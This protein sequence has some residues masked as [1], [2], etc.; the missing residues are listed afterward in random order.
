M[1]PLVGILGADG[2]K[3][4]A[5]LYSQITNFVSKVLLKSP[6]SIRLLQYFISRHGGADLPLT[7]KSVDPDYIQFKGGIAVAPDRLSEAYFV[8]QKDHSKQKAMDKR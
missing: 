2:F 5:H 8:Y 3:L 6:D 4:A 1:V 7:D